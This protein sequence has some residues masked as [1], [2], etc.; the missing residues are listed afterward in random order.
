MIWH[1]SIFVM[2]SKPVC[3]FSAHQANF[4]CI[5]LNV[6]QQNSESHSKVE[7]VWF[8][9]LFIID[10]HPTDGRLESLDDS[11]NHINGCFFLLLVTVRDMKNQSP[12]RK[13][14]YYETLD[15]FLVNVASLQQ[16]SRLLWSI[17]LTVI[18]MHLHFTVK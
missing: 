16:A 10:N 6:H 2:T 4:S 5:I 14:F 1:V 8:D 9:K 15:C 17:L 18:C 3:S 13:H 7:L 11:F 12:V